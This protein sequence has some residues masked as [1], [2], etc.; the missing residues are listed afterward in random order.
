MDKKLKRIEDEVI[1]MTREIAATAW[2]VN[3]VSISWTDEQMKIY[4]KRTAEI[5]DRSLEKIKK[6]YLRKVSK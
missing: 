6:I 1:D 4:N 3:F 5:R 2:G